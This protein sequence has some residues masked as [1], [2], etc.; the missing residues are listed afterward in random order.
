MSRTTFETVINRPFRKQG[1]NGIVKLTVIAYYP[2]LRR[3]RI[4]YG[5]T[6]TYVC[7]F[8]NP[9]GIEYFDHDGTRFYADGQVWGRGRIY[10]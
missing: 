5:S 7:C 1:P 3:V 10:A 9:H 2:D 4:R 6:T 8:T